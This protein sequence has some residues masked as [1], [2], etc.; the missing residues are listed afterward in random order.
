MGAQLFE[1]LQSKCCVRP[2]ALA[3]FFFLGF[4]FSLFGLS[5]RPMTAVCHDFR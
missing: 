2:Y 1:A 3:T 5:C 4:F